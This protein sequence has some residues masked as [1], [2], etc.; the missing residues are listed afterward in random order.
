MSNEM[1]TANRKPKEE[2]HYDFQFYMDIIDPES[3]K[4][5]EASVL[6]PWNSPKYLFEYASLMQLKENSPALF[7]R[8]LK[9]R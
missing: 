8:I 6:P 7:E 3:G 2:Y 5:Y 4:P 1:I 9:C